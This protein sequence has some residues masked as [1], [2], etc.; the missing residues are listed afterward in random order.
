[1]YTETLTYVAMQP[2]ILQELNK[3]ENLQILY[4]SFRQLGKSM[5]GRVTCSVEDYADYVSCELLFAAAI[6][7]IKCDAELEY[8]VRD[9]LNSF[10]IRISARNSE[11]TPIEVICVYNWIKQVLTNLAIE[12]LK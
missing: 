1:M 8:F 3:P 9:M 11:S 2:D 5:I 4:D 12:H 6:G 10:G 7:Q